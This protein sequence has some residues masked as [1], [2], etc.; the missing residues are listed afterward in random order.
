MVFSN[1]NASM[2]LCMECPQ[3]W[4]ADPPSFGYFQPSRQPSIPLPSA[5]SF[6]F[7]LLLPWVAFG[8]LCLTVH[9]SNGRFDH[10]SSRCLHRILCCLQPAGSWGNA[11]PPCRR[12][13]ASGCSG[14]TSFDIYNIKGA[15][16]CKSATTLRLRALSNLSPGLCWFLSIAVL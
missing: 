12:R 2:I 8:L 15:K 13:A 7:L 1:L 11:L 14:E 5:A 10:Q 3:F 4:H 9:S 6:L 16:K